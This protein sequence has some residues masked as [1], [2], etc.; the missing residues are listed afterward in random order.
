MAL[1]KPKKN[2]YNFVQLII[3]YLVDMTLKALAIILTAMVQYLNNLEEVGTM[4][5]T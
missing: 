5:S 4:I 1:A 2:E 3:L